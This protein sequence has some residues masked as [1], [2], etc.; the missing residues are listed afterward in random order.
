MHAIP[1]PLMESAMPKFL[2]LCTLLCAM[3]L[4]A[5]TLEVEVSGLASSEGQV[6]VALFSQAEGWL[7]KPLKAAAAKP[8]SDG[9]AQ[10]RFDDLPDGDYAISLFHDVNG[11]GRLDMNVMGM[12]TESF[13]FSNKAM[14][15]FGPPTFEAARFSVKGS[16]LQQFDLR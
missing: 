11:N 2:R 1:T 7:K 16:A 15:S 12:P 13:A 8:L 14:G 6:M 9:R 10:L 4:H 3:P 5:A